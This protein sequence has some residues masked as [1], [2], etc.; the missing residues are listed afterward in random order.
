[1][2]LIVVIQNRSNCA[3]TSN[4]K[5]EVFVGDG[6]KEKS[7]VIARGTIA[8]HVRSDG[9]QALVNRLLEQESDAHR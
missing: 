4:Y 9:W 3:P 8:G 7:S 1:M 6:T 2:A 5:Y